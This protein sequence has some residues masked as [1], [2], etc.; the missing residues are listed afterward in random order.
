MKRK[1]HKEKSKK[2]THKGIENKKKI[3]TIK[4]K[5]EKIKNE[6]ELKIYGLGK[7]L[8]NFNLLLIGS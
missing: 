1:I 5:T 2:K 6:E 3:K 4:I 8:N 7:T